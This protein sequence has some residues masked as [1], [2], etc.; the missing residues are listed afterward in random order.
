[1]PRKHI[2]EKLN[3][4]I[5]DKLRKLRI[6]NQFSQ[7]NV[8]DDINLSP[9]AYSKME[10]GKTDFS[11]TRLNQFA[12][13]FHIYLPDFLDPNIDVPRTIDDIY[14]GDYNLKIQSLQAEN[15][16]LKEL[17]DKH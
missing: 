3:K 6:K 14:V 8:A 2:E 10:N 7:Q 15:S 12:E 4:E 1:M 11:V 13:Y 5:G 9:T 16:V 17:I